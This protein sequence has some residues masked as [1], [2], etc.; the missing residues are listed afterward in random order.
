MCGIF[1]YTGSADSTAVVL[2]G[3]TD[4]EYRG[5]DSAGISWLTPD[6]TLGS[7]KTAG[8]VRQLQ[9]KLP[10]DPCIG[11]TCIGHTRWATHG[12]PSDR[13]AHPHLSTD[14]RISVVH[15]GIIENYAEIKSELEAGGTKF[16]SET[17]SE[18]ISHL[19]GRYYDGDLLHAV[20]RAIKRLRGTYA[21]AVL[22]GREPGK[23]IGARFGSPLC[24]GMGE[25]C[26]LIASDAIP[27]IR[28]TRDVGYLEDNDLVSLTPEG[29]VFY[30]AALNPVEHS[31]VHTDL[32]ANDLQHSGF[33][34]F[35][36]KEIF[37]QPGVLAK[38]ME[39]RI[40]SGCHRVKLPE[41]SFGGDDL[42][43]LRRIVIA[44]CGTSWHAG[45]IGR[46]MIE[47]IC[48]IPVSVEYASDFRYRD[49]V[50]DPDVLVL[51]I[52]QSGETADT[53]G[54]MQ[55][56]RDKGCKTLAICNVPES[57]IARET[58]SVLYTRAGA[59]IGVASTKAFT[60]QILC[61]YLLALFTAEKKQIL[62]RKEF[63]RRRDDILSLPERVRKTLE[64]HKT[65]EEISR[66][67]TFCSNALF[68]G[69]GTGYPLA[70]EGALKLK[71]ISY[72]HAEG[73]HAGEMKHGPIALIDE[74]MPVIVLALRGRRYPKIITNI[75]EVK[76]RRGK[77]VAIASAA[78]S[79]IAEIV[80]DVI[81]IE[82]CGGIINAI[83]CSIPL[84]L[85]AYYTAVRRGCDVDKPRNLAKSVTVE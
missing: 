34:H 52:S 24:V 74:N 8:R 32:N 4:L 75:Q 20:S 6:G 17:D 15:N 69:R 57:S 21:I 18:V 50:V 7:L 76:S 72:I 46:N 40:S 23:I 54:A 27:L 81:Y 58:G 56:A 22:C 1:G 84:Q 9:D 35:M 51:G 2:R 29:A 68:L 19:V 3:L 82:D 55:T 78:D 31:F 66:K 77:V 30:D 28:H 39:D 63:C 44:A 25:G 14:A 41:L 26:A 61:L 71:E 59:E 43:N 16:L 36:L 13:N 11:P 38:T 67:Y 70:L 62:D 49:P 73:Y 60:S 48:R 47:R 65:V 33:N 37:E 79:K 10:T 53:L 42:R 83:I 5:Y 85:F 64:N 45:L 80:D 12:T